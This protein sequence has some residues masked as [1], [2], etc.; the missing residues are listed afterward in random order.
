MENKSIS[1][2]IAVSSENAKLSKRFSAILLKEL[3]KS[4]VEEKHILPILY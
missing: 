3:R 1:E 2:L 4:K